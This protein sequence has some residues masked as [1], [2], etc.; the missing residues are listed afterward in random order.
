MDIIEARRLLTLQVAYLLHR[1]TCCSSRIRG[2][3][4]WDTRSRP[5]K[6]LGR[7]NDLIASGSKLPNGHLHFETPYLTQI[8]EQMVWLVLWCIYPGPV[9]SRGCSQ[10]RPHLHRA[11]RNTRST[12]RRNPLDLNEGI[13]II[14]ALLWSSHVWPPRLPGADSIPA[15]IWSLLPAVTCHL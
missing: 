11:K 6:H 4:C 12:N 14:E 1:K 3:R 9:R 8:I 13:C 2:C 5:C 15:P 7:M 10:V